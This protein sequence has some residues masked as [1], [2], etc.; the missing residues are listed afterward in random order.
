MA[1][2]V[3]HGLAAW[4]VV[5]IGSRWV[6]GRIHVW[7]P[8]C[9]LLSIAPD[10]DFAIGLVWAG[11]PALYHQGPSHSLLAAF[12]VGAAVLPFVRVHEPLFAGG[13]LLAAAYA[14][15]PLIDVFARDGRPPIGVPLFWPFTAGHWNA[16]P[17]FIPFSHASSSDATTLEW[18]AAVFTWGNVVAAGSE[19]LVM[20]PLALVCRYVVNRSRHSG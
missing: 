6:P 9:V 14:T 20:L 5:L 4:M 8:V 11:Q 1:S 13:L 3:A 18:L 19:L 17:V 7:L 10:F 12:V 2:P 15:H 16:F